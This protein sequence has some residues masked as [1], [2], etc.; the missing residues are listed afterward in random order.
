LWS[1][2]GPHPGHPG[3]SQSPGPL[4][5]GRRGSSATN[6]SSREAPIVC[7]GPTSHDL[8]T[9]HRGLRRTLRARPYIEPAFRP[10][11]GGGGGW[12]RAQRFSARLDVLVNE[13][14]RSYGWLPP[15]AGPERTSTRP[16]RPQRRARACPPPTS[17]RLRSI[18]A[19]GPGAASI[20]TISSLAQTA[21]LA[22]P[23]CTRRPAAVGLLR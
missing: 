6:A 22:G 11:T 4:A 5:G 10:K 13:R 23:S 9:G 12:G 17:K 14:G 20:H 16:I 18:S 3:A 19:A 21:G 1:T 8:A 15:R 7:G 2:A